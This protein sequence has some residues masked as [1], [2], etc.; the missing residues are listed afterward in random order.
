MFHKYYLIVLVFGTLQQSCKNNL[1]NDATKFSTLGFVIDSITKKVIVKTDFN[2]IENKLK[3]IKGSKHLYF[4]SYGCTPCSHSLRKNTY[5]I[6][7]QNNQRIKMQTIVIN[8]DGYEDVGQVFKILNK[9]KLDTMYILDNEKYLT[10]SILDTYGRLEQFLEKHYNITESNT[11]I[12]FP[13][14]MIYNEK[15]SILFT[16]PGAIAD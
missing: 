8:C 11:N 10:K 2:K 4:F 14:N 3:T 12:G 13:F 6:V 5:D 7:M 9:S 15:D 16:Y 1:S